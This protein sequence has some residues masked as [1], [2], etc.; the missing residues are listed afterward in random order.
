MKK[1][2]IE[3][4]NI[5]LFYKYVNKK[6]ANGCSVGTL[7]DSAGKHV[8]DDTEKVDLLNSY[9]C[10]MGTDDNGVAPLLERTTPNGVNITNVSFSP[11]FVKR[12]IKKMKSGKSSGRDGLSS[13]IFKQLSDSL[14]LPLSLLFE[15]FMSTLSV[16]NE[17]RAAHVVPVFKSGS[18]AQVDNYH[19]IS[20]T[21]IACKLMERIINVILLGYLHQHK[22]IS[23][24]QHGFLSRRSTTTNILETI[25]DWSLTINNN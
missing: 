12:A 22:L 20:L 5:G 8:F 24:V 14:A 1:R 7:I 21:C 23:K 25:N 13:I 17:W 15:S 3:S 19:P 6:I 4:N 18:S 9:F 10:S 11:D 2:I 16:P